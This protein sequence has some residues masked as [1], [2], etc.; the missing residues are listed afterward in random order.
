MISII[1]PKEKNTLAFSSTKNDNSSS[2]NNTDNLPSRIPNILLCILRQLVLKQSSECQHSIKIIAHSSGLTTPPPNE[3]TN[4]QRTL[5]SSTMLKT[6]SN[7]HGFHKSSSMLCRAT[8]GIVR[9]VALAPIRYYLKPVKDLTIW[10]T[11]PNNGEVC[12]PDMAYLPQDYITQIGQYLFMLPGQLE[13]YLSTSDT[14]FEITEGSQFDD[15]PPSLSSTG[16]TQCLY[17]GDLETSYTITSHKISESQQQQQQQQQQVSPTTS[18]ALQQQEASGTTT[19]SKTPR[20]RLLSSNFSHQMKSTPDNTKTPNESF[21]YYWLENLISVNVCD[22]IINTILQIGMNKSAVKPLT[23]E[24]KIS[25]INKT[26][27]SNGDED[28]DGYESDND[29]DDQPLLTKHG[30]KQL[31]VD[32]GMVI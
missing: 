13:P 20:K 11:Y 6:R 9:Q 8:V 22:L 21:V 29:A 26:S 16:L 31:D 18:S 7:L 17:L 23:K 4:H 15:S 12:L 3:M 19:T 1:T 14:S 5:T 25:A 28:V 32:L 30:L 24:S 2:N 27:K 10:F